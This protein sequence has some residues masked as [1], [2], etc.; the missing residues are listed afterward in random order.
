MNDPTDIRESHVRP[1]PPQNTHI[2]HRESE[3]I[4][5]Y[6]VVEQLKWSGKLW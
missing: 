4:G 5:N 2:V 6:G 1:E 3:D